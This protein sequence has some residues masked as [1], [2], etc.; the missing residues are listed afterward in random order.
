MSAPGPLDAQ[1]GARLKELFAAMADQPPEARADALAALQV[2]EPDLHEELASLR[3]AHDEQSYW[4]TSLRVHP[5][6]DAL[7]GDP[8]FA[9]MLRRMRLD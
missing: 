5:A 7:R 6:V 8:R 2:R 3:A 4:M 1:R 9:E